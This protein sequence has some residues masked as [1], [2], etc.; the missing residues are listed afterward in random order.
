MYTTKCLHVNIIVNR[1]RGETLLSRLCLVQV[2][3]LP[4]LLVYVR[5]F[6]LFSKLET[7]PMGNNRFI[8]ASTSKIPLEYGRVPKMKLMV[9]SCD[10]DTDLIDRD[11]GILQGDTLMLYL[12]QRK[13]LRAKKEKK[14]KVPRKNNYRRRLHRWT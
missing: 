9:R 2:E 3:F 10:G 5:R 1:G 13:R 6:F 4:F 8:D 11:V 14:L 7:N 12:F